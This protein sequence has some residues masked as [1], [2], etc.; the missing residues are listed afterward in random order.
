MTN[1]RTTLLAAALLASSLPAQRSGSCVIDPSGSSSFRTL[2]DAI[3]ALFVNGINGDVTLGMLPGSYTESVMVPPIAGTDSFHVH[4]T[5]LVGAGTVQLSGSGGDT[6]A[7]LGVSFRHNRG[8]VFENL[9]FVSAPGFAIS[10]TSFCEDMEISHCT[11]GPNHRSTATGEFR[12][13]LIVSENSG[14]EIG[15]Q[16]HHCTLTVPNHT[17]RTAYGL[18]LSNGGGWSIS[19]NVWNLN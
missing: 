13:A 10:G 9:D 18:Y 15:W 2:T 19:D 14:N 8:L 3:N 12:H 11:F 17:N 5:A 1:L 4:V 16:I 6:I 7:L